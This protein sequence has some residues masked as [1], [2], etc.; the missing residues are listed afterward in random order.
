M[1]GIRCSRVMLNPLAEITISV[2]SKWDAKRKAY[3][4]CVFVMIL[5]MISR[6]CST[7]IH[8]RTGPIMNNL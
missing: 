6:I 4:N 7:S 3:D 1:I 5:R 8:T 2:F